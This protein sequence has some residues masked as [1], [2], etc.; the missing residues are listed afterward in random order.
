MRQIPRFSRIIGLDVHQSRFGF[1]VLE[2]NQALDLL[3]WGVSS[4]RSDPKDT[5]YILSAKRIRRLIKFWQ[6]SFIVVLREE[7]S[8]RFRRTRR[9]L[10]AMKREAR[11]SRVRFCTV[12][13][14]SVL[15]ALG[16]RGNLTKHKR[17]SIIAGLF[18][19]LQWKLPPPRRPGWNEDYR[20]S[21]FDATAIALAYVAKRTGVNTIPGLEYLNSGAERNADS[22]LTAIHGGDMLH[23]QS[24]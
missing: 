1:A 8:P 5:N 18:P 16:S 7:E 15:R 19:F 14:E 13:R 23:S 6:P 3:D 10:Q 24:D 17:A 12:D 4:A 11:D 21:L 2:V 9:L 20:L 22:G